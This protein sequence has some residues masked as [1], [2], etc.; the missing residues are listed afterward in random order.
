MRELLFDLSIILAQAGGGGSFGGGGGGGGG[1]S[2]GGGGGF[3]GGGFSGGGGG[4]G[5]SPVVI[6]VFVVVFLV[7]SY[8]G[9]KGQK[10]RVTRTIRQGV[11]RQEQALQQQTF[12]AIAQRDP[13]FNLGQ[14]L[15]RAGAGFVTTQYAWS[16][17]DL[18]IC[19]AF[20][21]DGVYE[22]F[23]L[24]IKMQQ[25]ENIRNRMRDVQVVGH[26][27][28]AV[29]SDEHFDTIHVRFTA[30]AI[31]FN[32]SLTTQRRVSG[33][34]DSSPITFTEIWSFSRRPGVKTRTDASI[35]EGTCPNCGSEIGI[36][37]RAECTTCGSHINSGAYDW[38][39]TEITQDEEWIVPSTRPIPGIT[40]LFE[41][42]PGLNVQHLEDR[43][44]V[45]YWRAMM[46]IY[47]DDL[48][49]A[50][51]VLPAGATSLP[52][53]LDPGNGNYWFTPAVGSVEVV[54]AQAAKQ[55]QPVDT[56]KVLVR[57]SARRATGKKTSPRMIDQQRIYSDVLILQRRAGVTSNTAQTFTSFSCQQCGAPLDVGNATE[58]QFCGTAINDGS[59]S[60]ILID[61]QPYDAMKGYLM[62]IA[63]EER[64]ERE[65]AMQQRASGGAVA[66]GVL[67]AAGGPL[68]SNRLEN[69]R[70]ANE[71]ELMV[72]LTMMAAADGQL[73]TKEIEHL[74]QMARSRG[75]P[76]ERVQQ[77]LASGAASTHTITLP[78]NREQ[79]QAFMSQLIRGALID[80]EISKEERTLLATVSRQMDWVEADLK[81]AIKQE[82]KK[83]YQ[84]SKEILRSAPPVMP[85]FIPPPLSDNPEQN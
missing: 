52:P 18:R 24:Y 77:F 22:R 33:N 36:V 23:E 32:E 16:E 20:I 54:G 46:A 63:S 11:K 10:Q 35:L 3:S 56:V 49:Q 64:A 5:G 12:A 65:S 62:E 84:Q 19:R 57:W 2:G 45:I 40:K 48:S 25:A 68:A 50:A 59:T 76:V 75:I 82:R 7:L 39:L 30:R 21:S 28:V 29:N 73:A 14:F 74:T 8:S 78:D 81:R 42:D 1:F 31:S 17:Q 67:P 27:V 26:D 58:C 85:E 38:V 79:A 61:V 44:S 43:A 80:G 41:K 4:G 83:L 69:D 55:G 37:D 51:P 6:V 53:R 71:P 60:W 70:L 9:N 66:G 72:A 13:A 34:S 47:F 15:T